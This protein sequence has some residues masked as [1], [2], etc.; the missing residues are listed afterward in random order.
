MKGSEMANEKVP[1]EVI[2]ENQQSEFD[3]MREKM[4]GHSSIVISYGDK[5]YTLRFPRQLVKS[6]EAEGIDADAIPTMAAAQTLAGQDE[7]VEKFLK[8]AF[9]TE[10]PEITTEEVIEVWENLGNKAE[11]T[12]YLVLLFMQPILALTTD[13]TKTRAKFR[14]V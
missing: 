12:T 14:L 10:Q 11:I 8:R 7:Y 3:K 2:A 9:E 13:P 5:S 1:S 6:M 4:R